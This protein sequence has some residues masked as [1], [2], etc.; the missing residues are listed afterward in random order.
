MTLSPGCAPSTMVSWPSMALEPPHPPPPLLLL[1]LLPPPHLPCYVAD[2][3]IH[4]PVN[5][6]H[7]IGRKN[8][9]RD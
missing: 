6:F 1:L 2:F 8:E 7:A 4:F 5:F 9:M 3:R